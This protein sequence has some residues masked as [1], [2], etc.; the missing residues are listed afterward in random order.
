[1]IGASMEQVADAA[2]STFV[3]TAGAASLTDDTAL[4]ETT[5]QAVALQGRLPAVLA[6]LL[7]HHLVRLARPNRTGSPAQFEVTRA[8]IGFVDL[9]GF[10]SLAQ[11]V[12]LGDVGRLLATFEALADECVLAR[13]GR[14]IKF[15]GDA[16]MF[17]VAGLA[18]ACAGALGSGR[19]SRGPSS[20]P[21]SWR[22]RERRG[23]GARGRLLRSG[24]EPG[25]G[26]ASVAE[27]S[28][29]VA[30]GAGARSCRR[31]S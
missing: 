10:T 26:I 14:V 12:G 30:D 24:G 8:A 4:V 18:D 25:R 20:A 7:R 2:I 9:V 27:P 17:R 31:G 13:G 3:T 22:R 29:V 21:G 19:P 15:V 5:S 6:A 1:M 16:V 11:R 28:T 23:A